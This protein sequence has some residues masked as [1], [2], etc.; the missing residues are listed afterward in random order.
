VGDGGTCLERNGVGN[1]APKLV[2]SLGG[3]LAKGHELLSTS[4][5]VESPHLDTHDGSNTAVLVMES[6][7]LPQGLSQS[8]QLVAHVFRHDLDSRMHTR[9]RHEGRRSGWGFP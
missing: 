9:Y 5:F 3:N 8:H 1:N 6:L 7:D 4:M 2:G